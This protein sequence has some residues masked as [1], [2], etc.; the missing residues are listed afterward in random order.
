MG[1]VWLAWTYWSDACFHWTSTSE[2]SLTHAD[3]LARC[4]STTHDNMSEGHALLGAIYLKNKFYD[5]AGHA[6]SNSSR[7]QPMP[8]ARSLAMTLNWCG[9]PSRQQSSCGMRCG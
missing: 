7:M 4:A 2:D 1:F 6:R 3:E 5:E 8:L 9:R